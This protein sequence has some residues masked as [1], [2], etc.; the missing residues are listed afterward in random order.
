AAPSIDTA[1][2]ALVTAPHVDHLHPDSAIAIATATDGER[3]TKDI[4]GTKV[5]WVPWRRPGF[6]L[7]LDIAE[8]HRANPDAVGVILGGHGITAWGATSDEAEANTRWMIETAQSY[9]DAHGESEPFG[10]VVGGREPRPESERRRV[11][12]TLAP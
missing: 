11:A 10:A 8:V 6:Q 9:I 5:G 7:A 3:L 12:A 4:Y 2:H 1:M